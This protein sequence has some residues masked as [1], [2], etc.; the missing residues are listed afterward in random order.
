M[1]GQ[2]ISHYRVLEKLGS[3]GMGVVYK[4]EDTKFGRMTLICGVISCHSE[5]MTSKPEII[6]GPK[7]VSQDQSG[8]LFQDC[9]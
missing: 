1:T 6:P 2:T 9:P 4:A 8:T 5:R 3:G 7:P